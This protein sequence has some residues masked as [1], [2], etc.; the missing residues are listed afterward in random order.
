MPGLTADFYLLRVYASGE[1]ALATLLD[2]R[3][4]EFPFDAEFAVA[5]ERGRSVRL[6]LDPLGLGIPTD[7]DAAV[8]P[9]TE[10]ELDLM[11]GDD[12]WI[13]IVWR[14]DDGSIGWD[15]QCCDDEC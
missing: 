12:N 7:R 10:K 5:G 14:N 1:Q 9:P 15:G 2:R 6:Y 8:D 13:I 11:C 3:G 4:N